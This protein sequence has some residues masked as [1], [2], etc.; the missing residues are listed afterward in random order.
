MLELTPVLVTAIIFGFVYNVI[1]ILV[2]KSERM[3]MLEKGIDATFFI[4]KQQPSQQALKFG[5]LFIG[6]AI[7]I[8][9]GSILSATTT[10]PEEASYFSM[11]FLFG[12]LGLV[13][14]HFIEKKEMKE[15][16]D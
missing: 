4:S 8:L 11:I 5:L 15:N 2:R 9:L 7:G 1:F 10:L 14:N 3:A 6:V 16:K 13:I 12:G